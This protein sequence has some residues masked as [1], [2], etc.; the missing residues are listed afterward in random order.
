METWCSRPSELKTTGRR[1]TPKSTSAWR[2]TPS[3]PSTQG[4]STSEQVNDRSNYFYSNELS[5][6]K[7]L[8]KTSRDKFLQRLFRTIE[9]MACFYWKKNNERHWLNCS[10][11]PKSTR[12]IH[13]LVWMRFCRSDGTETLS[14]VLFA[15]CFSGVQSARRTPRSTSA[16]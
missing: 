11:S 9:K 15:V 3:A 8:V 2:A 1:C 12:S 5:P 14:L 7:F 10:P 4:M 16:N 13:C 6:C